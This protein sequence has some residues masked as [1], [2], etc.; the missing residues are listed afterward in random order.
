MVVSM[1]D[2]KEGLATRK[3]IFG[4]KVKAGKYLELK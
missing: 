1:K 2:L 4:W 3:E